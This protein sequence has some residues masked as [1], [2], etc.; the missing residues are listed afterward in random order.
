MIEWHDA[1]GDPLRWQVR[2]TFSCGWGEVRAVSVKVPSE[3]E[4]L[5]EAA[6]ILLQYMSPGKVA[7][8][9]AAWHIGKGDYVATR[10]QLFS[11]ETVET[12]VEK[13][14]TYQE[15]RKDPNS[16]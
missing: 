15:T 10:Q 2:L 12:L 16:H 5:Q 13:V 9:W 3:Q 14:K 4:V 6:E 7:R 8:V 1:T 11:G